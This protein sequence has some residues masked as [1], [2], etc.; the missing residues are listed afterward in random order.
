M[1]KLESDRHIPNALLWSARST[2]RPFSNLELGASWSI[3]WGGDGQPNSPKDFFKA[4]ASQEEC[5]NG[6]EQCDPAQNTKLGNQIA[7]FDL[8]WNER[9]FD[10]PVSFYAQVVG[11]DSANSLPTDKAYIYGIDTSINIATIPVR[12]FVE[13]TETDVACT[14]NP[15][16]LNCYYEH[17]TYRTGYRYQ[18]R[19]IGSTFDNDANMVTVGII[20]STEEMHHWSGK[21]RFGELNKDNIDVAFDSTSIGNTVSK[22]AEDLVELELIYQRPVFR[23]MLSL[24]T[25]ISHSTFINDSSDT[26]VN[27]S[28]R[29]DYRY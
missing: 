27:V 29:W 3:Q 7:G 26:D 20:G 10:T 13:Y 11:E 23:G 24:Q 5:S 22:V 28:A 19:T 12:I 4:L 18:G 6:E 14:G 2:V 16:S 17:G 21:L 9:I 25:Q 1:A 15:N 8:R